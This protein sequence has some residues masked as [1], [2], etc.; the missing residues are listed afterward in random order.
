MDKFFIKYKELKIGNILKKNGIDYSN[1]CN[2]K[3][4]KEKVKKVKKYLIIE[5]QRLILEELENG[6]ENTL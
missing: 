4:K 2:G 3:V 5:L 1:F 6:E